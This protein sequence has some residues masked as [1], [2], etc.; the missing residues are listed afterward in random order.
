[1]MNAMT[2]RDAH[3]DETRTIAAL[4]HDG[5]HDAHAVHVPEALVR[6]RTPQSFLERTA[7]HLDAMRVI[8]LSGSP[9]GFHYLAG[10]EL[11][12]FYVAAEARGT[13]AAALLIADAEQRLHEAGIGNAWLA[14][15]IG[16]IR[17]AR[18]YEKS[19][20]RRNG[21]MTFNAETSAGPLPLEAWRYEKRLAS[22]D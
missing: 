17:A 9:A 13:G 6:L 8:D 16:N 22:R 7:T 2:I 15:A 11:D 4:W 10:D 12:Q 5:W 19:G 21:T 18:F 3:P 14:C 20:W 1:M